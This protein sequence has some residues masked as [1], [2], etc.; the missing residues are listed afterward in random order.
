MM[1][2]G[3]KEGKDRRPGA[4]GWR[5]VWG[6]GANGIDAPAALGGMGDIC[7]PI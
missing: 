5:S 4:L 1:G 7:F 3:S 2:S 6:V